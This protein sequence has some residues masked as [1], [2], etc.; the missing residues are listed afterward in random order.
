MV[1]GVGVLA[2]QGDFARHQE[3]L[4]SLGCQ[5]QPVRY[6]DELKNL[7]ALVIP[8]GESATI[9]KQLDSS[10]LREAIVE[11]ARERPV[12]GTCAGLILM[13]RDPGDKRVQSLG[14]LDVTVTRNSWGRQ[15]HSFRTALEVRINGRTDAFPAVFI[16]APRVQEVGPGVEVLARIDGEPVLVRQGRHVGVT[17]HPELTDDHRIHELFLGAITG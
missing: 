13:C 7:S 11:F 15:V 2:L 16:R 3:V 12:M 6:P 14:L 1:A 4:G 10:G 8:G 5:V 9:S 17:F